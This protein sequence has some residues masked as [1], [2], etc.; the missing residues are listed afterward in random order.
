MKKNIIK[1]ALLLIVVTGFSCKAELSDININPN[2]T[3]DPLPDY[4]LTATEKK[5]AD[6]YWGSENNYNSS[7]LFVQHWAK[8]QYTEPDCYILSNSSFTSLWN[9]GY[10]QIITNLNSILDL[11]DEKA[12]S[13]YKGVALTL[14]SWAF[15]LLTDAYGDIPYSEVGKSII[16][17]YDNQKDV[18]FGLLADLEN[19]LTLFNEKGQK[20][21]GDIIYSGNILSWKK[22]VNALKLRIAL[23]ISDKEPEKAKSVIASVL[24]GSAGLIN[25]N[26]ETAQFIYTASPQQNPFSASFETRDDYRVSKTVVDRLSA[27]NDPRLAVFAQK[28]TD[29][30]VPNYVGVPN[31]L[32]TTDANNLGFAKTS[33]PGSYFLKAESP[34]VFYSYA[35][36]LFN[37]SEAAARGFSTQNSE[38]LYNKAITASLNQFGITDT[39]V[40]SSYLSQPD[41]QY[42]K[43]NF[44]KS[45]G[46]QKWISLY[47][48]GLEAF[49]EWRRLDYPVLTAGPAS[50]LDNKLPVR[51]IYPGAE[52]SLNGINYKAAVA[53]QGTDNLITKL[54]FDAY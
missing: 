12:N 50:V 35:E 47:G 22:F 6:L 21:S 52:Q 8:I 54:W 51:F 20:I 33:K 18:Y 5:A 30:S 44:K 14:R 41:V 19:S 4:L 42:D 11:T 38:E 25:S 39:K 1:L 31:G 46:E 32:S 28:P 7:L 49:A 26:T 24:N 3:E 45:I 17:K 34:A 10:T 29:T 23:R 27:I 37:L 15:L 43:T 40:I 9:T 16:P 13:N 2:A 48:Q 53:H 36:V